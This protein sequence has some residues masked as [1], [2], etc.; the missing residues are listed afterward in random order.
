VHIAEPRSYLQR[1]ADSWCYAPIF[2]NKAANHEN[3]VERMKNVMTFALAGLSN[4]CVPKKPFNP[5]IGETY[6]AIFDDGTQMFCEQS[7]HH[8][9]ISNW[10]VVGADNAYHFYGSGEWAA[11]FRGNSI[12]G[13]QMGLHYVEF[14]DGGLI[15]F[16]LPQVW[17][18]GIMWGDRIVEYD[19]E[20]HFKDQK[21]NLLGHIKLNPD[22]GGWFTGWGRKKAPSDYF[23]GAIERVKD[24]DD[25]N[26][27][28]ANGKVATVSGSWL[29]IVEFDDL[30]YWN[31]EFGLQKFVP[32]PLENPLPSD[33]RFREDINNLRDGS[34]ELAAEWK[35]KIEEKQR[36][37]SKLRK[38]WY[39]SRGLQPRED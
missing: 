7:S 31:W 3:P 27:H 37:E 39:T 15:T 24:W 16:E 23:L 30:P 26:N 13:H 19:G 6:E 28:E 12:C 11:S 17:A 18:R 35:F 1:I 5:V 2:L 8:P 9:P 29:G 4:T 14:P 36:H 10:E 32:R 21:N 38:A 22:A 25:F 20:V 33:S 34:L